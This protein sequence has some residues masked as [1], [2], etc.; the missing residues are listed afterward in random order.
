MCLVLIAIGVV[1][2][3]PLLL[4]GNRDEFHGRASAAAQPWNEDARIAGGR[5]LVAGGTWL[6]ARS[7]GRFATVTNVRSGVPA[8]APK[9][10]GALVRDFVLGDATPAAYLRDVHDDIDEFGRADRV[11]DGGAAPQGRRHRLGGRVEQHDMA[12]AIRD[13]YADC[14][15]VMQILDFIAA[16][17]DRALSSPNRGKG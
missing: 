12:A 6:A 7:D 11:G 16:E 10:R 17:S 3:T 1:P 13:D 2:R 5:D 4:L 8:T 14:V 9:S 15:P